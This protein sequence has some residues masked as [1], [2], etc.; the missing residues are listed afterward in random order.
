MPRTSARQLVDNKNTPGYFEGKI[1]VFDF[2]IP[3]NDPSGNEIVS[4]ETMK[5]M[6]NT[7]EI[8]HYCFQLEKGENTGY[9]HYQCRIKFSNKKDSDCRKTWVGMRDWLSHHLKITGFNFSATNTINTDNKTKDSPFYSYCNKVDTRL[10]GPWTDRDPTPEFIS[11]I[12]R[13]FVK[14]PDLLYPAQKQVMDNIKSNESKPIHEKDNRSMN[15]FLDLEGCIGKST[16]CQVLSYLHLGYDVSI[17]NEGREISK[18]LQ[19]VFSSK[20]ERNPKCLLVDINKSFNNSDKLK[21]LYGTLENIISTGKLR[22]RRK[23]AEWIINIPKVWIFTNTIPDLKWVSKDRWKFW[24]L[25]GDKQTGLLENI[26]FKEL[27]QLKRQQDE[28]G[29][30]VA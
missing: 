4:L 19:N 20:G 22:D 29:K 27:M 9:E 11:D 10:Q 26:N 13:D 15:V 7:S 25:K 16:L 12:Y 17:E 18:W 3:R 6:M 8:R 1:G 2:T 5:S 24:V 28:R 21:S 23:Y 14:N 30:M